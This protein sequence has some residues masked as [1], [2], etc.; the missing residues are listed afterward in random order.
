MPAG[1]LTVIQSAKRR[2]IV[3]STVQSKKMVIRSIATMQS[4][5]VDLRNNYMIDLQSCKQYHGNY[6]LLTKLS[7]QHMWLDT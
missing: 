6:K 4:E 7:W 2:F 3:H 5:I 1:S